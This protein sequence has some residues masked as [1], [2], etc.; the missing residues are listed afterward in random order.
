VA[1]ILRIFRAYGFK[2]EVIAASIRNSRQVREVAELGVHIATVPF[3]VLKDMIK[4]YKTAEGI[5]R[6]MDDIVPQ[7]RELFMKK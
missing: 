2:T 5:R 7:Y 4:H 3:N 1:R 6:F